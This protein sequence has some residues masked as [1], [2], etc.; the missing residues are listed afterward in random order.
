MFN[1]EELLAVKGTPL[2]PNPSG[3]DQRIR[4]KMVPGIANPVVMGDPV[5]TQDIK[6]ETGGRRPFYF[7][8]HEV[9]AV[10]SKIGYTEGCHGCR[11]VKNDFVSRPTHTLECRARMEPEMKKSAKGSHVVWNTTRVCKQGLRRLTG[12]SLNI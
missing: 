2:Q 9:R 10:A 3:D 11:A 5:T 4:T 1:R 7:M 6:E 8:R 12:E